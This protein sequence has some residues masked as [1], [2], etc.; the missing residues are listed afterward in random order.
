MRRTELIRPQAI[1]VI[2]IVLVLLSRGEVRW[3]SHAESPEEL[4]QVATSQV[5]ETPL[6]HVTGTSA[7]ATV[8]ASP[9]IVVMPSPTVT[10]DPTPSPTTQP[11]PTPTPA[12]TA[13]P[14][15]TE[16]PAPPPTGIEEES[17]IVGQAETGRMEMAI[18]FDAGDGRG[19][20]LEILDLLDQYGV[21]AS[22]GVTGQW[23]RQNPDLLREII[24]REHHVM[25]HT[26]DHR[27]FTGEST[28]IAPLTAEER[29]A[30]ILD[31]EQAIWEI[32]GYEVVPFFRFPYGDYDRSALAL[33]KDL[34]YDYTM[35]W[36]CDSKAWMG[37]TAEEIVQECGVQKAAPGAIV[38]LHVDQDADF[39]ALPDL[40]ETLQADGYDLVS[41]EQLIQP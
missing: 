7:P 31:T 39:A 10:P 37:N 32:A 4:A 41:I 14:P 23:A 1:V 40:I 21:T 28:G 16:R 13:A 11:S 6:V 29:R 22:F 25:N 36:S 12:P 18:T 35:W 3:A 26:Y 15:P 20:T 5:T 38:L 17:L 9:T 2:F 19:H 33:L 24:D 34:D 8:A 30:E 27:S